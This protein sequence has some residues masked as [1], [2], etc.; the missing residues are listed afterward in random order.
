MSLDL[1]SIGNRIR[2]YRLQKEWTLLELSNKSGISLQQIGHLERGERSF[3]LDS[4]IRIANALE[5]PADELLVDNLVATNS[6]RDGDEYYILLDC[7]Q[8]E[9]TIL[10]KNMKSLKE[11]LRTY[12]IR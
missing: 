6:K 12:S 9:A 2:F 7:T 5:L 3:S 11:I 10:I 8:E 1:I 4:L